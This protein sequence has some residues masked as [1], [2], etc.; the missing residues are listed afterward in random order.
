MGDSYTNFTDFIFDQ[1]ENHLFHLGRMHTG[2]IDGVGVNK[3]PEF[4]I[5]VITL[6]MS[7][8]DG[9]RINEIYWTVP[10]G[11]RTMAV[12]ASLLAK[13]VTGLQTEE[14]AVVGV[15]DIAAANNIVWP[16]SLAWHSVAALQA[17]RQALNHVKK[18]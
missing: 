7:K 3:D 16:P 13:Y 5:V 2:Q 4:G 10:R 9:N 15:N 17:L 14:A 12:F 18:L 8:N 1:Y 6:Q 11:T